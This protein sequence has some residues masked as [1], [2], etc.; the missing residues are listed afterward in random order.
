M[1]KRVHFVENFE[2][3][4][5]VGDVRRSGEFLRRCLASP[6]PEAC[7]N[8]FG[9]LASSQ[10]DGR[11]RPN[12]NLGGRWKQESSFQSRSYP[13]QP[14]KGPSIIEQLDMQ[15]SPTATAERRSPFIILYML[16]PV[17]M[18]PTPA[19]TIQNPLIEQSVVS[20]N[21]ARR[22]RCLE[23]RCPSRTDLL[24]CSPGES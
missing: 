1:N 17:L 12:Q 2:I 10:N 19:L 9:N 8:L 20:C 3:D 5:I 24:A 7:Q 23:R 11:H 13:P 21:F 6:L 22:S 14:Q 18:E 16:R 4:C 15:L